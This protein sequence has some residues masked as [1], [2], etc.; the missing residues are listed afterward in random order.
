V[1]SGCS[2]CQFFYHLLT[3][4]PSIPTDYSRDEFNTGLG[5]I[6]HITILASKYLSIPLSFP[7]E[8][9][10]SKS[11]ARALYP[12]SLETGQMPLHISSQPNNYDLFLV[13]FT[14]IN[15][16]LAYLAH[17]QGARIHLSDVAHSLR[18]LWHALH[19]PHLGRDPFPPRAF[20][21]NATGTAGYYATLGNSF[22]LDFGKCIRQ[23]ATL[24]AEDKSLG[25][26]NGGAGDG[27]SVPLGN[28]FLERLADDALL[29]RLK[30]NLV[31]TGWA[32]G[33]AMLASVA[34]G[35]N[36]THVGG[37]GPREGDKVRS[38]GSKGK[39]K[40]GET[41]EVKDGEGLIEADDGDDWLVV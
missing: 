5:Y 18:T 4:S 7:F 26:P 39:R 11:F 29:S 28:A 15:Y 31:Q 6:L 17:T 3:W 27:F 20:I 14:M 9:K 36:L 33:S 19:S 37:T 12:P 2:G 8:H 35:W 21:P 22:Q 30:G 1:G 24:R 38:E 41:G 10:G 25:A 16:D 13:G 32:A 34:G 40:E 23:L